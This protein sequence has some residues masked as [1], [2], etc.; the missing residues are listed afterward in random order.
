MGL[1][2][3][4]AIILGII[5]FVRMGKLEKEI[6]QL[7]FK[8]YNLRRELDIIRNKDSN[9]STDN[10]EEDA[11]YEEMQSPQR[12][13]YTPQSKVTPTPQVVSSH[14]TLSPEAKAPIYSSPDSK[15]PVYSSPNYSAVHG[16][17][18]AKSSVDGVPPN[19]GVVPPNVE[20]KPYTVDVA[21]TGTPAIKVDD[22]NVKE[23][24]SSKLSSVLRNEY[25]VGVSLFNRIGALLIIIGTVA[26]AA[27]EGFHPVLRTGILFMLASGVVAL[28][29]ILNRKKPTIVSI[30]VSATG[31][32]LSYVAIAASFFALETLDRYTA[33]IACILA[34]AIGIFLAS[35][36]KAQ[37]IGCF[38]LIGGYLPIF[39]IDPRNEIMMGGVM[40]YFVLLAMF[41]L[42]IALSRKWLAMNVIGYILTL[43]G[44]FY[45]GWQASPG[46]AVTYACFAL[47]LYTAIP[48]ISTYRTKSDFMDSD[49]WMIICNTLFSS[50]AIFQIANRLEVQNINAYLSLTFAV[51]YMALAF[52]MKRLFNNKHIVIV[53]TLTSI[54]FSALFVPFY[55]EAHWYGVAWLL[56]GVTL[57]CYGILKNR[58]IPEYCG[59]AIVLMSM[60]AIITS[61]GATG[62]LS[63]LVD[64]YTA[65]SVF[66]NALEWQFTLDYTVFTLGILTIFGCYLAKDRVWKNFDQFY[67]IVALANVWLYTMYMTAEYAPRI[68]ADSNLVHWIYILWVA[69]AFAIACLYCKAKWLADN[70]TRVLA[71][72]IHA[73]GIIGLWSLIA[74]GDFIKLSSILLMTII[75]FLLI[76]YYNQTQTRYAWTISYKNINLVGLWL[77]TLYYINDLFGDFF[78]IYML[79]IAFT[80]AVAFVINKI[81]IIA[82]KGTYVITVVMYVGGLL[83]LGGYN[84]MQ[85]DN[86]V[87]SMV[88]NVF[89]Q[90]VALLV[91]YE[92]FNMIDSKVKIKHL[93]IIV[94]PLY[95]LS[96]VIQAMIVQGGLSFDSA[97]ISIV[98]ALFAFALIVVGFYLRNKPTRKAG[99]FLTIASVAKLTVIDTWGL[100]IEMRIIS[101]ISLGLM[102]MAISFIYHKLSKRMEE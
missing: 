94:L 9:D 38:A 32:A 56:Q 82:D 37:V 84:L 88:L 58:K 2:T 78:G 95:L 74:P 53:F 100:S 7:N 1:I 41:S 97:I 35:R 67:K 13:V 72:V 75:G 15:A 86:M 61:G 90:V 77:F 89:M 93:R 73:V 19:A 18:V 51:V 16:K 3:F 60:L 34:T 66:Y 52:A 47:L 85:Y 43:S 65:D 46:L 69:V 99:L 81:P 25:W 63:G 14:Q 6:S 24:A 71:N 21:S 39:A 30:G 96:V 44:V 4:I 26:I 36:Y 5:L 23:T 98:S 28:G 70:A 102:L 10:V 45:I 50:I 76:V 42:I 91:L 11:P 20:A 31:V 55:F 83:W 57:A 62:S 27:F 68:V 80:F 12:T 22:S 101:Y 48:I 92:L 54:T 17:D 8:L 33:L 79:L 49:V 59:I 64:M 29:E 40:V 87:G